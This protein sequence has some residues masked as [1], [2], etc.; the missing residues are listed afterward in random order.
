MVKRYNQEKIS[1]NM[2][3]AYTQ[4][5]LYKKW[6]KI[7]NSC[8]SFIHFFGDFT[9]SPFCFFLFIFLKEGYCQIYYCVWIS[10]CNWGIEIQGSLSSS[11][12]FKD[13]QGPGYQKTFKV[14]NSLTLKTLEIRGQGQGTLNF[15]PSVA[16]TNPDNFSLRQKTLQVS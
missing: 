16:N 3:L 6:M 1:F 14:W 13:F 4:P 7:L 8:F 5:F 11:L 10:V 15:N 12:N 9:D 2:Y